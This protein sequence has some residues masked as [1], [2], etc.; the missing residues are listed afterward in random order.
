MVSRATKMSNLDRE[1]WRR[2]VI[3]NGV[4]FTE[5]Q[6]S[7]LNLYHDLLRQWNSKINLISRNDEGNI[8]PGHILHSISPLFR[9]Q[10][11]DGI[12]IADIGSGGGLPGVPLAIMLPNDEVIMIESIKKKSEAL[13]EII[14]RLRITNA[15]VVNGRAEEL[16]ESVNHRNRFDLVVARAVASLKELVEWSLKLADGDRGLSIKLV[17]GNSEV[18]EVPIALPALLALKGGEIENEVSAAA[19]LTRG[20]SICSFDI[21]FRGIE[22]TGLVDKKMILVSLSPRSS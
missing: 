9:F 1:L 21:H 20:R 22:N 17:R 5:Q 15:R 7:L 13:K 12:T 4:A 14:A 3:E 11:P 6:F 8:W 10:F 19:R 18:G 16:S 2:I